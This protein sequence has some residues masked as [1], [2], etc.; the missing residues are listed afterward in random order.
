MDALIQS[1]VMPL[2]PVAINARYGSDLR[3][4]LVDEALTAMVGDIAMLEPVGVLS[5]KRYRKV[6]DV[7]GEE[8]VWG[9]QGKLNR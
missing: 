8:W 4:S 1:S 6:V 5:P 2:E 7:F 3:N 9:T